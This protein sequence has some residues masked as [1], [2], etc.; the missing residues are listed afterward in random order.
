MQKLKA[1][2]V[3]LYEST[4]I[5][6]VDA[7]LL[8]GALCFAPVHPRMWLLLVAGLAFIVGRREERKFWEAI[9]AEWK[10]KAEA[11]ADG[12]GRFAE[13]VDLAERRTNQRD[14]LA[15]KLVD[16]GHLQWLQGWASANGVPISVV[17]DGDGPGE[18]A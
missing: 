8:S 7:L 11:L 12:A 2:A 4:Y 5:W 13:A 16:L 18:A 6:I 1:L 14:A 3:R 10:A 9:V 17:S 15:Q